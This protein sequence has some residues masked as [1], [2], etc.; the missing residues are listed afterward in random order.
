MTVVRSVLITGTSTGIGAACALHLDRLGWR[1]FAGVRREEDGLRL[2][3]SASSR[4]EW[5]LLDVTSAPQIAAATAQVAATTGG[6]LHGLVNNAG[7]A[8]G[9]PLEYLPIQDLRRQL[10]VNVVGLMAVTQAFLPL[11]RRGRGRIVNVGSVAGRVTTP[12]LGP[13]CA[14]K[15]AVVALSDALRMELRPAGIAVV[16]VEPGPVR[17]PIWDKGERALRSA[18]ARYSPEAL[19]R[20]RVLLAAFGRLIRSAS[21]RGV[22]PERVAAVVAQALTARRPRHRCT[23]GWD[24]RFRLALHTL[25]PQAWMDALVVRVF[26]RLGSRLVAGGAPRAAHGNPR[27]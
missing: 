2:R 4:L 26:Q 22:A 21:R 25:L 5:L 7:T 23:V 12:M 8:I 6:V 11:L 18:E 20:Y 16:L 1:V 13:Y 24:A 17:T 15:H 14:S 27:D 9:G 3:E 19:E 10:E